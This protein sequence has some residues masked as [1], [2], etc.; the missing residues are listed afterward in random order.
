MVAYKYARE[1]RSI[2]DLQEPRHGNAVYPAEWLQEHQEALHDAFKKRRTVQLPD[3]VSPAVFRRC[4]LVEEIRTRKAKRRDAAVKEPARVPPG[5]YF[6][7]L[8]LQRVQ[9]QLVELK[10][11]QG[12]VEAE[13]DEA[14]EKLKV[15]QEKVEQQA[16]P[17]SGQGNAAASSSQQLVPLDSQLA[18]LSSWADQAMNIIRMLQS[19]NLSELPGA[20]S[21]LQDRSDEMRR[22]VASYQQADNGMTILHHA[23]RQLQYD[24]AAEVLKWEPTVA[25]MTT[26]VTSKPNKWT[27]LQCMVDNDSCSVR[28]SK[29]SASGQGTTL[30]E[31]H[32]REFVK[33]LLDA[34][35]WDTIVNETGITRRATK[36]GGERNTGGVTALHILGSR[37]NMAFFWFL[38]R[39]IERRWHARKVVL[40]LNTKNAEGRGVV[41]FLLASDVASAVQVQR[42]FPGACGQAAPP[43]R[44]QAWSSSW[45]SR[46][47]WYDGYTRKPWQIGDSD[48]KRQKPTDWKRQK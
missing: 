14:L 40:A 15:L 17:A 18:H 9:A 44:P 2:V 8:E 27:A 30:E 37:G 45:S 25:N 24:V 48:W 39:Y 26:F 34:M 32:P 20:I 23:C 4:L 42:Q 31:V 43:W 28:G 6:A 21:Y 46:D 29:A 22:D 3:V 33:A 19:G 5:G 10:D 36:D 12:S 13:R 7:N 47:Q 38:C 1:L 11:A 16:V 35:T 41:D